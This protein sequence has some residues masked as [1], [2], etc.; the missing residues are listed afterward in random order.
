MLSY[1]SKVLQTNA[2]LSIS[3]YQTS[4]GRCSGNRTTGG[5]LGVGLAAAISKQDAYVSSIP[6]GAVLGMTIANAAC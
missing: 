3:S 5:L 2:P 1:S 6:L 4:E